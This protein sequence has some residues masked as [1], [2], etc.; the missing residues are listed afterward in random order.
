MAWSRWQDTAK[1]KHGIAQKTTC[2]CG[3]IHDSKKE[4]KRCSELSLL[5]RSGLISNL[6]RHPFYPFLING[7]LVKMLNGHT[8]GV[9]LDFSYLEDGRQK[10][11]DVKPRSKAADSRDWPLRK[12]IF[13]HLYPDIEL[14]E[15]R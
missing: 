5:E 11:E 14:I 13:Q 4:Q 1:S 8:A 6:S 2:A 9:T 15:K 10:A 3:T 12:A 7:Q